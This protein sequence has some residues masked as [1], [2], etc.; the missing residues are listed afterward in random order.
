MCLGKNRCMSSLFD[1]RGLTKL[2]KH[3]T[4][5]AKLK[6]K[7][8]AV[9]TVS[10][11]QKKPVAKAEKNKPLVDWKFL[12]SRYTFSFSH[13]V[14]DDAGSVHELK[15]P[16][17]DD[18]G[19]LLFRCPLDHCSG[20]TE[21]STCELEHMT[22]HECFVCDLVHMDGHECPVNIQSS[23]DDVVFSRLR[24]SS[25]RKHDIYIKDGSMYCRHS[26]NGLTFM[27]KTNHPE[28]FYDF[29]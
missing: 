22:D 16:K 4:G 23:F 25:V 20:D 2:N 29:C 3:T 7:N 9:R 14:E 8:P 26:E 10:S 1:L 17:E 5:F 12:L 18:D 19:D 21:Q 13:Y 27:S 24:L 15:G 6:N 11:S 28:G